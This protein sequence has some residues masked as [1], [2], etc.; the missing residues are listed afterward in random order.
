MMNEFISI[1]NTY[2]NCF[3]NNGSCGKRDHTG[4]KETEGPHETRHSHEKKEEVRLIIQQ[5]IAI[6]VTI[7]VVA[8]HAHTRRSKELKHVKVHSCSIMYI[9]L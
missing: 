3:S 4:Q 6:V 2:I 7:Y 5:Y 8:H 1:C 9:F